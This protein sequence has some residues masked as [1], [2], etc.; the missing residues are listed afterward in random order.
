MFEK[1]KK[2]DQYIRSTLQLLSVAVTNEEKNTINS[3]P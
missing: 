2:I 3:F 1:K